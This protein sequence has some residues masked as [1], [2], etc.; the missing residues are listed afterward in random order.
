M[1]YRSCAA[2]RESP[3]E[4]A[5]DKADD[6]VPVEELKAISGAEFDGVCS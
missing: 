1:A 4:Y 3:E 5:D 2:E 6:V